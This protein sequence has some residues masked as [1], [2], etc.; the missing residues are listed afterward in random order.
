MVRWI[1]T[2]LLGLLLIVDSA[3]ATDELTI[4]NLSCEGTAVGYVDWKLVEKP[5]PTFALLTVD[6][7][8]HTVSGLRIIADID[9]VSDFTV[10]FH[11]R[12]IDQIGGTLSISGDIN[13]ETGK[14][15]I[16]T[17]SETMIDDKKVIESKVYDLV[18]EVRKQL[19]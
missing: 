11:N 12:L 9:S 13:R 8:E 1:A 3:Q 10:S 15:F 17:G 5:A 6:L 2:T 16:I 19:F 7:D 4:I 14:V 18:C